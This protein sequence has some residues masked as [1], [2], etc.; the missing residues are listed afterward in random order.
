MDGT[1]VDS[2]R[3]WRNLVAE[4]LSSKGITE[5]TDKIMSEVKTM[6]LSQST[7]YFSSV[8]P[9]LG[10]PEKMTAEAIGLM[11]NHYENDVTLKDGIC[12][13]LEKLR[14]DGVR[15]CVA[16]ITGRDLMSV[17]LRRLGIY[18]YFEFILTG[19]DIKTGKNT[20]AMYLKA[21][22]M[23]GSVPSDTAVFEDTLNALT[24]AKNA[25][26]YTVGVF[27][28]SEKNN[29]DLIVSAADEYIRSWKDLL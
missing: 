15:M 10:T 12:E 16:T 3:Y 11:A 13:Y 24:T 29:T 20:P 9:E 21:A 22:E 28:E 8:Y 5:N 27:D 18:G 26:F 1:L 25:G 6:T 14:A 19:S 23:L 2:M 17:C 4:F 7:L